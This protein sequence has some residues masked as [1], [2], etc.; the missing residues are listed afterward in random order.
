[1][2]MARKLE[3]AARQR[4]RRRFRFALAGAL[5][6]AACGGD[7]PEPGTP[8]ARTPTG[9]V[10]QQAIPADDR[11]ASVFLA[12][13]GSDSAACS[14]EAPCQ[15][16]ARAYA[17]ASPGGVIE[18]AAGTYGDQM[19]QDDPAKADGEPVL[20]RPAAGAKA[21]VG[22]LNFAGPRTIDR[23]ASGVTVRDL[24]IGGFLTQRSADLTFERVTMRGNF[25]IQGGRRIAVVGGSAGGTAD[26]SHSSIAAWTDDAGEDVDLPRDV[27]I[28]GVHLHDVRMSRPEDH[29]E[30]LQAVDVQGLVVRN[31]RFT[32]C[33]TFDLRIDR[34]RSAGPSGVVIE[35]NVFGRTTDSFGGRTYYGLA[36]R[37][38]SDVLIRNNSSTQAWAGPEPQ[39]PADGWRVVGNV[40]GGAGCDHRIEYEHNVWDGG[41]GC[42]DTDVVADPG[43]RDPAADDLRLTS[44][45]PARDAG[46]ASDSPAVDVTGRPRG[47]APDAGAFE[48]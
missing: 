31:N 36:V 15:T 16:L 20:I 11:E 28:D 40:F 32:G 8:A 12:P 17:V 21:T 33:D 26:G 10:P 23:G 43:F 38:G 1:M 13:D 25:Y 45:S 47:T 37:S 4:A 2:A 34:H 48:Y 3:A 27:L 5:A 9:P 35:N 18:L 7:P 46:A 19:L 22:G 44:G 6:L 24:T 41:E 29:V 39:E 30:C 14:R 42:G